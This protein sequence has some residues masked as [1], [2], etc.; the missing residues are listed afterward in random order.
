MIAVVSGEAGSSAGLGELGGT[1]GDEKHPGRHS[2]E[3]HE[4]GCDGEQRER[5]PPAPRHRAREADQCVGL[6]RL[7]LPLFL[8]P[9]NDTLFEVVLHRL[10]SAS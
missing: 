5:P 3:G 7:D 1:I 8:E 2:R 4:E 6:R 9:P 10:S